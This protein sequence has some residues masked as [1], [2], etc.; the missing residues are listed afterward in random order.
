[1]AKFTKSQLDSFVYSKNQNIFWDEFLKGF[2]VRVYPTG[3][4]SFI[5]RY[6][7]SG[8]KKY[9]TIGRYPNIT[10]SEAYEIAKDKLLDIAKGKDP[11]ADLSARKKVPTLKKF[12]AEYI[13][14]YAMKVKKSW[15]EDES[16]LRIHILPLIGEIKITEITSKHCLEVHTTLGKK[17]QKITANR[18]LEV[19]QRV[20]EIYREWHDETLINQA[21]K[22]KP[23]PEVKR[24][25]FVTHDE[26]PKLLW[27]IQ[28]EENVYIRNLFFLYLLTGR[29]KSELRLLKWS[30]VDLKKKSLNLLDPKNGL[31]I[32]FPLSEE[33][34]KLFKEIPKSV[35]NSYIFCGKMARQPLANLKSA[36]TRIKERANLDDVRIHDLRRSFGS[37]LAMSGFSLHAIGQLLGHKDSKT[38]AVYA[39][40]QQDSLQKIVQSQSDELARVF[41]LLKK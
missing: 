38:T 21:K 7:K 20:L 41:P 29:R 17:D 2:A 28:Q 16:K 26:M 12:S 19:L 8:E 10:L 3:A 6:T 5:I 30:E 13:T 31:P 37:W 32:S 27:S 18:T 25:R 36:W 1:L 35:G 14:D 33:A 23:Y 34:I 39:K 40:F 15:R 24:E 22:I 11:V 4:K 9:L